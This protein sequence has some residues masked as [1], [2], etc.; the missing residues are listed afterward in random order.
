MLSKLKKDRIIAK[1]QTHKSD[2]G[3]AQVQIAILTEEVKELTKHLKMHHHDYSS[4]KG[5]LKKVNERKKL[6]KYLR[7]EDTKAWE[8]LVKTLKLKVAKETED[9]AAAA[10]DDL[11]LPIEEEVAEVAEKKED[12]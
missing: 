8:E 11:A 4:R 12:E 10:E 2:T 9:E 1:F 7:K 5:L 6:L 3:S